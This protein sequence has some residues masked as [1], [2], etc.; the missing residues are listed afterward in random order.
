[1]VSVV[2]S[3][4]APGIALL[5]YFYLRHEREAEPIGYV[6][7]SFVFGMLLVFPI[8]FVEYILL[9]EG[10]VSRTDPYGFLRMSAVEEFGKW[11]VI[12]Y[13]VY[14]H[15]M[16]DDYYDGIIYAVACSLGFATLEN[17]LYLL[18]DGGTELALVRALLPVSGHAL[19]GVLMGF[20]MGK[21]KFSGN[22]SRYL[23]YS[24]FIPIGAHSLFNLI[25]LEKERVTVF[26]V[27]FMVCLWIVGL[28]QVRTANRLNRRLK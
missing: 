26:S 25:L 8:M 21:A 23:I 7:R 3:G 5:V 19:F 22:A 12:F 28:F 11:F 10:I 1:M 16:F 2:F 18:G 9:E 15:R 20:F 4:I 17:I 24:L 27:I 14:I 13:T 6:I